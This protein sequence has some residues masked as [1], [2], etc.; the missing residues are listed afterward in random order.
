[1]GC[2]L[3]IMSILSEIV[4]LKMKSS[5]YFLAFCLSCLS[6]KVKTPFE[7]SRLKESKLLK[8]K[9]PSVKVKYYT[10]F[11]NCTTAILGSLVMALS[12]ATMLKTERSR[13]KWIRTMSYERNIRQRLRSSSSAL[14]LSR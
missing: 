7:N 9:V 4:I 6:A 2:T 3:I 10:Y 11:L 13:E 8:L 14:K 5:L 12:E 1:M